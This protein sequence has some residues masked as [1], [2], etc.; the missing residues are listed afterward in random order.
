MYRAI[1]VLLVALATA[2]GVRGQAPPPTA[3]PPAPPDLVE[4]RDGD[5]VSGLIRSY[6][7]GRLIVMT[8]YEGDVSVKWNKIISIASAHQYDVETLDGVHHFGSL[9][10]SD[11]IGSLRLTSSSG[12]VETIGFFSVARIAPIYQSFWRRID[13]T[14]DLGLNYSYASSLTQFSLGSNATYRRPKFAL[15]GDLSL[16]YSHQHDTSSQ[17]G[18]LAFQYQL[19]LKDRWFYAG[20]LGFEQNHDLGLNLRSSLGVGFGR[21]FIQTNRT[22]LAALVGVDGNRETSTSGERT[23]NAEAVASVRYSTFTYDF[24]KV[25]FDV[26]LDFLPSLSESGRYRLDAEAKFKRELI[27]DF[28]LSI[29][30]YFNYDSKPPSS[31]AHKTDWGP[32]VSIG[33]TF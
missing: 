33:W 19:F 27:R 6:S 23:T 7:K 17:R 14:L 16:F 22:T 1:L 8:D 20:L 24:P 25:W 9:S 12:Q 10:P 32:I 13:G 5:R 2:P 3:L 29:A 28:Y 31:Q 18:S 26:Y 11:P 21:A 4:I 15:L 30:A